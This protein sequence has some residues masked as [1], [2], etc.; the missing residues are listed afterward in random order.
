MNQ[1]FITALAEIAEDKNISKD[2]LL[3]TIEFE[4]QVFSCLSNGNVDEISV[5]DINDEEEEDD[6]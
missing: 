5:N 6:D 4:N 3:E 1:E 2:A